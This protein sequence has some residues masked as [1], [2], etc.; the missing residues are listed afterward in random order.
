VLAWEPARA[1]R[2]FR[3]AGRGRSVRSTVRAA[4]PHR[5]DVCT[6]VP[7]DVLRWAAVEHEVHRRVCADGPAV[8]RGKSMRSCGKQPGIALRSGFGPEGSP[9]VAHPPDHGIGCE[10]VVPAGPLPWRAAPERLGSSAASPA[11]ARNNGAWASS[12]SQRKA[13]CAASAE[14]PSIS[15]YKC[16][17]IRI[18]A[19]RSAQSGRA[20]GRECGIAAGSRLGTASRA[21]TAAASS[22]WPIR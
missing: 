2:A 4:L 21:G 18:H 6:H 14:P 17:C 8:P 20:A 5:R 10:I 12:S 11:A 3:R 19:A 16:S 9:R 7:V 15:A 13:R 1:A 22:R